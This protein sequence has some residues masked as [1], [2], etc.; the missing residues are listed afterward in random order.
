MKKASFDPDGYEK[1]RIAGNRV[2]LPPPDPIPDEPFVA[3]EDL[4]GK[5]LAAWSEVDGS[6]PLHFRL[7][8]P[9]GTGKNALVYELARIL[10]KDLYIICGNGELDAEDIA[11]MP[12]IDR[13]NTGTL[14]YIASPLFAAMVRGG[15]AFF[16]EIAKAP[17]GTLA[18]LASALDT[19][20]TL[21]SVTAAIRIKAAPGFLFCAALNEDEEKSSGLPDYI[22]ERTLPAI[23]VGPPAFEELMRIVKSQMNA[24]SDLWLQGFSALFRRAGLSPRSAVKLITTAVKSFMFNQKGDSSVALTSS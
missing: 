6:P 11:C 4:I 13:E 2:F 19:R 24:D 9:P 1:S 21:T 12:V 3:R 16:D 17:H 23:R 22:N 20:S 14:T 18:A 7:Y 10:Q 15:I 5:A 8:G